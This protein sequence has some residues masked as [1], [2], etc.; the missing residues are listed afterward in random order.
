MSSA[1]ISDKGTI[2]GKRKGKKRGQETVDCDEKISRFEV[3]A[4]GTGK[5]VE[6]LSEARDQ[7]CETYRNERE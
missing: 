5:T 6:S 4:S 3:Y 1:W 2:Q 7:T